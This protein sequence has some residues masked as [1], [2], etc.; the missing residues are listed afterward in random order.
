MWYLKSY[1]F[2]LFSLSLFKTTSN[3]LCNLRRSVVDVLKA[4]L[5]IISSIVK[6]DGEC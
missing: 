3:L 4:L 6:E 5:Q 2:L 1:S